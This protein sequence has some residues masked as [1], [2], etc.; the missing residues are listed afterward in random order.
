[1]IIR[2]KTSDAVKGRWRGV[3]TMLGVDEKYLTGKH[4]A[5]PACGGSDRFRF[6]DKDGNGTYICGQCGAGNGFNLLQKV[7][8][9][10]FPRAAMEVDSVVGN[11]PHKTEE[12]AEQTDEQKKAANRRLLGA[13]SLVKHGDP[14][15][16]YLTNRCGKVCE[17]WLKDL[18][19]H[20]GLKHSADGGIH[21][22]MLSIL[23]YADGSGVSVHRTFITKGGR[24]ADVN[25]VR[26]MMP[27]LPLAGASVQL[28]PAAE[29]MGV[30]EG[31]ETA[32]C[33]SII[34]GMPVW[35]AISANGLQAWE[36]PPE[37]KSIWVF[38]DNDLGCTGQIASFTLAKKLRGRGMDVEIQI[39][40]S[41]GTDWA[42]VLKGGLSV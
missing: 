10:E 40:P 20:P 9:W 14:T 38:G 6:D 27:G 28:A 18:R 30:A 16:A 3:L 7:N 2:H 25:P 11:I 24:K 34:Y 22:A 41:V 35:S 13:A 29:V 19:T 37:A 4:T 36:P 17:Q 33:A 39:P 31:L 1:M 26:M 21:P 32:L 12:R 8:G 23:R 42:D 5:C 15:W